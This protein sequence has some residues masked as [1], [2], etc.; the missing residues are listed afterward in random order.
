LPPFVAGQGLPTAQLSGLPRL[1]EA[2]FTGEYPLAFIRFED[3]SLPLRVRVAAWNPF[4]PMNDRDSGMPSAC[5]RWWL[6]NPGDVPV[7]A[8]L[9]FSLYNACGYDGQAMLN[10]RHHK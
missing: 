9:A 4:I 7:E 8:S 6:R 2:E 1:K 10:N 3:D 5:F